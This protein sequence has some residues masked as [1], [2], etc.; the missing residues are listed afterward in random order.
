M[1]HIFINI[2]RT[3]ML[4]VLL[5]AGWAAGCPLSAQTIVELEPDQSLSNGADVA[6]LDDDEAYGISFAFGKNTGGYQAAYYSGA[7]RVYKGN[8][9]T[10][11]GPNG[12]V[13]SKVEFLTETYNN[14][15]S[16]LSARV[17][18]VSYDATTKTY[19]WEN[20]SAVSEAVFDIVKGQFRIKNIKCYLDNS[21]EV[22]PKPKA[23][24]IS[25]NSGE[26]YRA[27]QVVLT[28]INDP[29]TTIRYTLDGTDPT[30]TNGMKYTAPVEIPTG[31]DVT[32]KA[33]CVN[34]NGVSALASASYI[35]KAKSLLSF[36]TNNKGGISSVN[37]N[38][39][40]SEYGSFSGEGDAYITD[41]ET[42]NLRIS[43]NNGYSLRGITLNG[44]KKEMSQYDGLSFIMPSVTDVTVMAD[45]VYD[46]TSPSD[47]QPPTPVEKK[48]KLTLVSNPAGAGSFSG[49]G[50][51]AEGTTIRISTSN[52]YGYVFK[53]W[54]RDGETISAN[55]YF[56]FTMPATD[57]VLV[58]NYVYNPTSP[59]DP[60][61]PALKHPLTAVASP[62]GA[63]SF[64]LSASE[65]VAGNT[66]TV[67][68]YPNTG[69][70]MK[71]WILNGVAQ[72]EKSNVFKGTMTDAGAQ[73]VAILEYDPA[74]PGNPGANYYNAATGLAIIDDFTPD[75][76]L[77]ALSST[78]GSNN[79]VNVNRLIV[80]G[81]MTSYDFNCLQQLSNAA[82][83]DLSRTGGV[84]EL[85]SYAFS[86]MAV[87]SVS[88]PATIG[89]MGSMVFNNCANLTAITVHAVEP[90]V[91]NNRTFE[92]ITNKANC[93]VYV[94]EEAVELYAAAEY[95]KD[96]TILPI[97]DDMHML[98]VNLPAEGKDGRYKNNTIELV[99]INSGVR[100]KYVITDRLIYTFSGLRKDEQYNVYMYSR[101]GLEI[102]RIE[103]V[104]IPNDDMDVAFGTLK[105]LYTVAAKVLSPEGENLTNMATVEWLKPLEDGTTVYLRK[106]VSLGEIP[107]GQQLICRVTLN[108]KLGTIY[109]AP[110]DTA[111]S[112]SSKEN[113]CNIM[114][115]PLRTITLKGTVVDGDDAYIAD[116]SVSATQTL[117]GKFQ[118]TFTTKT[119]RRGQ[120]TLSVLAA[121][122]T[123]LVIAATECVNKLDTL[124]A[125][126]DDET[127][128]EMGKT[129][130]KSV[131]GARITYGFTY[132]AAGSEEKQDFY[133]DHRNVAF[134]VFNVTQNREQKDMTMQYPTLT[135]L[136]ETV[137]IG[138]E[139]RITA[140][141][142]TGAF[143]SIERTVTVDEKRRA[144]ATFDIVGKGCIEA[145][146]ETTDNPAVMAMLYNANGELLKKTEY[147]E[148]KASLADV[149]DGE[150]TLV[151]MGK[152]ELM[153]S[154]LRL[155]AYDEIGLTD[156]KDY[157]KNSVKVECGK[158]ASV[159]NSMVPAFD[160]SLFTY[161]T[162]STS[163]SSNK[164]SI[165][166][167]K[168]LTLSS[169]IDFK[170]VYKSD[171]S[172]VKLVVDLPDACDFVE[173][174][175]IQGPK[176]MTYTLS[177]KRLT[178]ELGDTY[179][180]QTRF[181]VIPTASEMFNATA[182]VVFDYKG[183]TL[184]QP[185]GSANVEV[186][187]IEINVP[188]TIGST[189][190]SVT[191][192]ARPNST[193][194]VY[195]DGTLLG[196]GKANAAGTWMINCEL[197]KAYNLS[198]HMVYAKITTPDG[199]VMPT[200]TKK[201]TYDINA[202]HVS[203]VT[204]YHM[205]PAMGRTY[206]S[207]FDFQNPKTSPTQWSVYY[208][209]KK[210]T[211]TIEF[212]END[213][214]RISNVVLYV[215]T[216]DGKFVPCSATYDEK[217]KMW[218]AE[219]DMGHNSDNYYPVNCS[220][221]F[222]SVSNILGDSQKINENL[223][224]YK[225][226]IG[227]DTKLN[228]II[229]D[230]NNTESN[231]E[232]LFG[233]LFNHLEIEQG[234]TKELPDNI[235]KF[236]DS[237]LT[238]NESS[239]FEYK[240]GILSFTDKEGKTTKLNCIYSKDATLSETELKDYTPIV[241]TDGSTLYVNVTENI[242]NAYYD[243]NLFTLGNITDTNEK[244]KSN[245]EAT[246]EFFKKW[247][248]A[249][250][251]L[252]AMEYLHNYSKEFRKISSFFTKALTSLEEK[253]RTCREIKLAIAYD[254]LSP[255]K[256]KEL[257]MAKLDKC[258][259]KI[260]KQIR[261]IKKA[262]NG[263]GM[264]FKAFDIIS[265]YNDIKDA[266]E[267]RKEWNQLIENIKRIDCPDMD[268]LAAKAISYRD[269]TARGYNFY[270]S[271][272]VINASA[273]D[274]LTAFIITIAVADVAM[275]EAVLIASIVSSFIN[276][277]SIVQGGYTQYKDII[278]KGEI[279]N[280]IPNI[281]CNTDCGKPGMPPCR[282]PG[283]GN[284]GGG[285][286]Q[287]GSESDHVIIDPAGYVY[288][289][290]PENR[291][292]G[293]Q[294]TIYY[295]EEVEDIYGDKHENVVMWN[296]EEYAQHN[297][298]FT[299]ENG[300]YRWDVPQ[301][302]WQVKFEKD[303]YA[304][305]YSEWLPVP[306]PQLEV[307]VGIT[308]NK[309][310]E[311][312]EAR[313]YEEGIEVQFDKYMDP[314]SL[315]DANISVTAGGKKLAGDI[316]LVNAALADEYASPEDAD[317][318]RYASRIRFVPEQ[319]LASTTGEIRLTVSRNVKSYA[320]I[321][322]T[323]TYSQVLDVEK[324]VQKITADNIKVLYGGEKELT[325]YALPSEAAS[326]RTLHIANS[327]EMVASLA[328]TDLTLDAEGKAVVKVTGD[329]PGRTQLTFTI[330]DVTAKGESTVDVMTEI[331]TAEAPTAS[332]ASGT[333][334]YRGTKV[335]L[336]TDSKN[337][338]IYFTTDGSCP[339]DENGTRRK[340]TVPIV[341]SSDTHIKAMTMVG[342]DDVSDVKEFS[343]VIKKS[344][345]DIAMAEGWTW[346]SHNFADGMTA[347]QLA[348]DAAVQRVKSQTQEVVRDPQLGLVGTLSS[349][350]ASQSYKVETSAA[351]ASR[352][353][354]GVAWN[355]ATPIALNDGWNW[356]GYP[357][358]QTMT[359]DEAFATTT[360]EKLDA[361]V[362]QDGFAQYDGE[363]WVGTL[364][365]LAPGKGYMYQ[366]QSKKN[367][368]Y[369]TAIVSKA[370]AQHT[371]GIG[372]RLPLAFDKHKYPS[373]MAIVATVCYAD[374]ITAD[375]A[376]Y[377]LAAF[378]GSECR[379][380]GQLSGGL[381][382]M[383]VYGNA[384]DRITV[385]VTDREGSDVLASN[386]LDFS[387]TVLGNIE[388][389]Y[390]INVNNATAISTTAYDG[391]VSLSV[392]GG[393]LLIHGV[394][395]D[396]I[397]SVELFDINGQKIKHE[398]HISDSGVDISSLTGG[399]YVAVV[400]SNGHY[401]YHKIAV[402]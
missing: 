84:T 338:T 267:S 152:S 252:N 145:S 106:T 394:A 117:N 354:S 297:P 69:Y 291:V 41:G 250:Q 369:N 344:D 159:H 20:T 135:I 246:D 81:R 343:Y 390:A 150:Y 30:D 272:N 176:L 299:D 95:W 292:E 5:I 66:Y 313:A 283:N 139:L 206:E 370:H 163:F 25:H 122:D 359:L 112:V 156:G 393:R 27:F 204:M 147:T 190:F 212:S 62:T 97:T 198:T 263:L 374:G 310:P 200:E 138:D 331:I 72:E 391:N 277:V 71:G 259:E 298:L 136:D 337:A 4:L 57:V 195:E 347:A 114:L 224:Q 249:R 158:I 218:F 120:W 385:Q 44:E 177:G 28:D 46:P 15:A 387:E 328:A 115:Q 98:Q 194:N 262:L 309:Q 289:A 221:D 209:Q 113:I 330:D 228:K 82:T 16:T 132:M 332:R 376:D 268:K 329:L 141:S 211:Y 256:L 186:K 210:F 144:E 223:N 261:T 52:N 187:D 255:E 21:G 243:G 142:K 104:T 63:A 220:V 377:Q 162:A 53:N 279:R 239:L 367:V 264:L 251:T 318:V 373:V 355:P 327:S 372:S 302:L 335:E 178:V 43:L 237:V 353:I 216:A 181:C 231:Y 384:G 360:V 323:V 31:N 54:T 346:M 65:V 333:A 325:I 134:T 379:G 321:P 383:S 32:L 303:G 96:F 42:V 188:N 348:E 217:K 155:S 3:A 235:A 288:E 336:A 365:T 208:P 205:N 334:V 167:G 128:H 400:C 125:F 12:Y 56:N 357:A 6:S 253:L 76:L 241:L 324:E 258:L 61:K 196:S 126:A 148:A 395:A 342:N 191:G 199:T 294:A 137:N 285:T 189:K 13:V 248:Q 386:T 179:K 380:I 207:V 90:P 38:T 293:V 151:T 236:V 352:R 149:D 230:I 107:E 93:N 213:P 129:M 401:T 75:N 77:G 55:S 180:T 88:L 154:I 91:C 271:T 265:I 280:Q 312:T 290:V 17:G 341:I 39:R 266:E 68:A 202:I 157:V 105:Q 73:L 351:T 94:P 245:S 85:P 364:E 287:S 160:E 361:V 295:K 51:Y 396:D 50:S 274:K 172:N 119:D 140:V 19:T 247:T 146:F 79:Y 296:A 26:F 362:G 64:N 8:T 320:G 9:I 24:I 60:E 232:Q 326:G 34:E 314:A 48:Y 11:T 284:N 203:K 240:N 402:R 182:S 124:G 37:Y 215:H 273:I 276:D 161:T 131:V 368:V 366:S 101:A 29:A 143:S 381:L 254:Q 18:S 378:C 174:S 89:S 169:V 103:E 78:V 121:P 322:M 173:K 171:I 70:K 74:S 257:D 349:L 35:Y 308:Q 300:M 222:E 282:I 23:P 47:P 165:T 307:N 311:V 33:V 127:I 1:K 392:D 214:E 317:A 164:S 59:S 201:L 100:Q 238:N 45:V 219:I 86:G 40:G 244:I 345:M 340:Y 166:N 281:K 99:N 225:E 382:M 2:Q 7:V 229:N 275:P 350:E 49:N 109:V 356:L 170:G 184:T 111:F 185:I 363:H 58:A 269:K 304:T 87:S 306:P 226:E 80:K 388:V 227:E 260:P 398:T 233:S 67:R 168:Y 83:I 153:S 278:W 319:A 123:R 399:V 14:D 305:A 197:A 301:G 133:S 358:D 22:K 371:Q 10:M 375:N 397:N 110:A 192:T 316:Q 389:P 234:D 339:C 183:A 102:G 270:I 130:M 118:K 286:H 242:I 116:A 175:V 108:D 92:G 315:T 36:R 193:I